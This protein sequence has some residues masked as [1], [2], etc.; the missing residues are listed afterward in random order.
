MSPLVCR[1]RGVLAERYER[2]HFLPGAVPHDGRF[3]LFDHGLFLLSHHSFQP[4]VGALHSFPGRLAAGVGHFVHI[5]TTRIQSIDTI[6][7]DLRGNVLCSTSCRPCGMLKD[8]ISLTSFYFPRRP[9]P[10]S[11][12]SH[13]APLPSLRR[14]ALVL[15][16]IPR[17]FLLSYSTCRQ[18]C[19]Q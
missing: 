7:L 16:L 15:S 5:M 19:Q 4:S 12:L 3:H 17:P 10:L 8:T 11:P 6:T 9:N 13:T 2:C 14:L 18:D 1:Q